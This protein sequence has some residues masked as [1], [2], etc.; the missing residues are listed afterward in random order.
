MNAG[1]AVGIGLDYL[2]ARWRP[3]LHPGDIVYLP[4]EEAQDTRSQDA[5]SVG[6]DASIMFRHDRA[7]LAS[8]PF[9]RWI[10][11]AFSFSPRA[12][13]MSLIEMSL[14]RSGFEDPRRPHWVPLTPGGDHVGH[15]FEQGEVN[16][17]RLAVVN[18]Y[19]E[20]AEDIATG[21]GAAWSAGSPMGPPRISIRAIGGLPADFAELPIPPCRPGSRSMTSSSTRAPASST[22]AIAPAT[23]A[24]RSSTRRIT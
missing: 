9:H 4:L 2:F 22:L 12:A 11:A 10:G 24:R 13:L 5:N 14:V 1:V 20:T 6:P 7:T 16:A 15:T 17:A 21:D 19:D 18:P 23:H 8:L 3:L